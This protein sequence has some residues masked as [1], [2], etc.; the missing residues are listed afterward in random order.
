MLLQ[1]LMELTVERGYAGIT[2]RDITER[3]MVNRSTFYRHYLDKDDL[4]EK[5]MD[6][7][8]AQVAIPVEP[9]SQPAEPDPDGVP[10]GLLRLI[11]HLQTHSDFYRVMLSEKGDPAFTERFRKN[12]EKRYRYLISL[13][14]KQPGPDDPPVELR[15]SYV[16]H[17]GLG[18]F[19]WWLDNDQPCTPEQLARWV[20][21]LGLA[22]VGIL[23]MQRE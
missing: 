2:V 16:S 3:A 4:L 15:L 6:E 22:S 14:G 9:A 23:G 21:R 12:S 19:W 1:A 13:W 10:I 17:A 11:E 20:S 8:F 7:V 18:A 5:Y